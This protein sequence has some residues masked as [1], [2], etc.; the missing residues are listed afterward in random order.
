[1]TIELRAVILAGGFAT[2]LRPLSCSKPK[3]LFPIVGVP[4]VESMAQWLGSGGVDRIILAV[5]HLS[6]RLKAGIGDRIGDLNVSFSVEETPLGTAGPINLAANLLSDSEP[7]VV[8]NGDI[9]TD[10][11]LRAMV[12]LHEETKHDVT[13]ALVSTA[14]PSPFGSVIT[15]SNGLVRKFIEK[16][17]NRSA[18]NLVNAGVY[19]FSPK[20]IESI[21]SGRPTS[22]ERD[23]FPRLAENRKIQAWT[24]KGFWYDIGRIPEY[25]TANKELL[26]LQARIKENQSEPRR[27]IRILSPSFIGANLRPGLGA[28]IGP[29]SI[30]SH[31]VTIGPKSIVKDSI[32]FEETELGERTIVEDSLVG[33]KV[34]VGK[35]SRIGRG[36]IIA[37]QLTIPAG[38]IIAPN[39]TILF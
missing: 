39:S 10:I 6:E 14:D 34:T 18:S 12:A 11:D 37:G 20:L 21:P 4:L 35:D 36:S 16:S 3:L 13:I 24:H 2:R 19:I 30:L 31:D 25:I 23:I 29:N 38:T 32:I 1:V 17:D 28:A 5:N 33:E 15:D 9:V 7:F 26:A 8:V 22:L 27:N